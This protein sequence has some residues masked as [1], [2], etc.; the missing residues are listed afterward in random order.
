MNQIDAEF[1]DLSKN[2]GISRN[3]FVAAF[4]GA[5]LGAEFAGILFDSFDTDG[6]KYVIPVIAG[7][8][9]G[10]EGRPGFE[11][12]KKAKTI[13]G[14][15]FCFGQSSARGPFSFGHYATL[16]SPMAKPAPPPSS[17]RDLRPNHFRSFCCLISSLLVSATG[18]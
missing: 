8:L 2:G 4:T 16:T 10:K 3:K 14:S 7:P 12:K 5:G 6:N 11:E 18:K 15:S 13:R 1:Q 17:P 9:G